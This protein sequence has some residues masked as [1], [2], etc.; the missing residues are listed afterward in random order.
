MYTIKFI[1]EASRPEQIGNINNCIKKVSK[2]VLNTEHCLLVKCDK[3]K[4]LS[5]VT[6]TKGKITLYYVKQ[7]DI[8]MRMLA[9]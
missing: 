9:I 6:A 1:T 2:A 3:Y 4:W 7:N 5:T 8:N